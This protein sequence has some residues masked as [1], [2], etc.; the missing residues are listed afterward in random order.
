MEFQDDD[1]VTYEES[2]FGQS[3]WTNFSSLENPV[4]RKA[5]KSAFP[6]RR[7]RNVD[8]AVSRTDL[9]SQKS[10]DFSFGEDGDLEACGS[11]DHPPCDNAEN[12]KEQACDSNFDLMRYESPVRA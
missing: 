2:S 10:F 12:M 1:V 11:I 6:I 3:G 5:I 8:S 9:R 4:N 7:K